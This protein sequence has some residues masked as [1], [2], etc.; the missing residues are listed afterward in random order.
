MPKTKTSHPAFSKEI[1]KH[2]EQWSTETFIGAFLGADNLAA[3]RRGEKMDLK[4]FSIWM[5]KGKTYMGHANR[6]GGIGPK[7]EVTSKNAERLYFAACIDNH[8]LADWPH[9]VYEQADGEGGRADVALLSG[10]LD[11]GGKVLAIYENKQANAS[12]PGQPN[13]HSSQRSSALGQAINRIERLH[14]TQPEALGQQISLSICLFDKSKLTLSSAGEYYNNHAKTLQ[15]SEDRN[16]L[17]ADAMELSGMWV[18]SWI[19]DVES[20]MAKRKDQRKDWLSS[21]LSATSSPMVPLAAKPASRVA[22]AG[23]DES[24][25]RNRLVYSTL[26]G[27]MNYPFVN[28][29]GFSDA[30]NTREL[31]T[32]KA[33][34]LAGS[35]ATSV[36]KNYRAWKAAGGSKSAGILDEGFFTLGSND[37][38]LH[39]VQSSC[40]E[41]PPADSGDYPRIWMC[42]DVGFA[43]GQHSSRAFQMIHEALH[44]A[45][46]KSFDDF[47][48][49]FADADVFMGLGSVKASRSELL[50][51]FGEAKAESN[52]NAADIRYFFDNII[53]QT[54]IKWARDDSHSWSLSYESNN[55]VAQDQ[56]D[57]IIHKNRH[58]I[59]HALAA[60]SAECS[61]N[62]RVNPLYLAKNHQS[63]MIEGMKRKDQLIQIQEATQWL[64]ADSMFRNRHWSAE[65]DI[66]RS[67]QQSKAQ[68]SELLAKF[69]IDHT[70]TVADAFLAKGH[71]ISIDQADD[72]A[73]DLYAYQLVYKSIF[74]STK[75]ERET[76]YK[77]MKRTLMAGS[78][79][80]QSI[81]ESFQE[82]S[83][84][85]PL[86][87]VQALADDLGSFC[88][89]FDKHLDKALANSWI[90][91][92]DS[93]K[94]KAVSATAISRFSSGKINAKTVV[95]ILRNE[96]D[97]A[98]DLISENGSN[99]APLHASAM[100]ARAMAEFKAEACSKAS[101]ASSKAAVSGTKMKAKSFEKFSEVLSQDQYCFWSKEASFDMLVAASLARAHGSV[102]AH[103]EYKI[104]PLSNDG[105]AWPEKLSERVK[106]AAQ[107]ALDKIELM[108][109]HA[110]S[111]DGSLV[112]H[113]FRHGYGAARLVGA[114]A[115]SKLML[116]AVDHAGIPTDG[117]A[118]NFYE[119]FM[120]SGVPSSLGGFTTDN[121][122]PVQWM[123]N[124]VRESAAIKPKATARKS[125]AKK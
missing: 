122:T 54:S 36:A 42:G 112:S 40:F 91:T 31:I 92:T 20:L 17:A 93:L 21:S 13:D 48:R 75:K 30:Q 97:E 3:I 117:R 43:N 98:V 60:L 56:E 89:I 32:A 120:N 12:E 62:D 18:E 116:T 16:A 52:A 53:L 61:K 107:I 125:P 39:L 9:V 123:D 88:D 34:A 113:Y 90:N 55:A 94:I 2:V 14:E 108:T 59:K 1:Q 87:S 121:A 118:C 70:K 22:I 82:A 11:T 6:N 67:A 69:K 47:V 25:A 44:K 45:D 68:K 72:F 76:V 5:E 49:S 28:P 105:S 65:D 66:W 84:D 78:D 96:V 85:A 63:S 77:D 71:E 29:S 81:Q 103:N 110:H 109:T 124:A 74:S 4:A 114:D 86:K 46:P 100:C 95:S 58:D 26:E 101:V 99:P 27:M 51:E 115:G 64:A 35:I 106:A 104:E 111:V 7:I 119:W 79:L 8:L 24:T 41:A 80:A 33:R 50:R 10:A 102:L 38:E 37:R 73:G 19:V 15:A 57:L 83:D 23:R